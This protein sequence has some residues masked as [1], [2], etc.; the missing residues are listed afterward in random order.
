MSTVHEIGALGIN[1]INQERRKFDKSDQIVMKEFV[2]SGTF[3][4]IYSRGQKK[5]TK[6]TTYKM[7][8]QDYPKVDFEFKGCD[9]AGAD[10][11][12]TK[13]SELFKIDQVNKM[14]KPNDLLHIPSVGQNA[15]PDCPYH[16]ENVLVGHR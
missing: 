14:L 1:Q 2:N 7:W 6:D 5:K 13:T 8:E 12:I 15:G 4:I 16:G 3:G 10:A 9:S 11:E